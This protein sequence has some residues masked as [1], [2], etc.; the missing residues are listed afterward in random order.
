[1]PDRKSDKHRDGGKA[2]SS[3]PRSYSGSKPGAKQLK[4]DWSD[5]VEPDE[6]RRIQNRIG[7]SPYRRWCAKLS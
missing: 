7:E 2:S 6:R 1:M 5:V 3:K 4:D